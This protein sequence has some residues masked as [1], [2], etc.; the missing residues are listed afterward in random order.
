MTTLTNHDREGEGEGEGESLANLSGLGG[1]GG[2]VQV[3]NTH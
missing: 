1:R 2:F 3:E